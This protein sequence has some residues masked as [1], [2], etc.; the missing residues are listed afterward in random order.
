MEN[1]QKEAVSMHCLISN[2][3][4]SADIPMRLESATL[5]S[6]RGGSNTYAMLA[7][8]S[9]VHVCVNS[10]WSGPFVFVPSSCVFRRV[11]PSD[12]GL[13]AGEVQEAQAEEIHAEA[14]RSIR[15]YR[16]KNALNLA[17]NCCVEE[18]EDLDLAIAKYPA[19]RSLLVAVYKHN[20]NADTKALI[21]R[22][23]SRITELQESRMKNGAGA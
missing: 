13:D 12:Y 3:I 4:E 1:P 11:S 9:P 23:F 5:E 15:F 17:I 7:A 22:V 6:L 14:V 19:L 2:V 18:L 8:T 10:N 16:P 21:D 20:S